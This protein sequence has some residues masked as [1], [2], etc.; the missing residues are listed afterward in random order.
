MYDLNP[1]LQKKNV[2]QSIVLKILYYTEYTKKLHVT[3]FYFL[4]F[5]FFESSLI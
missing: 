2:L 3:Y 1:K 5:I 4:L